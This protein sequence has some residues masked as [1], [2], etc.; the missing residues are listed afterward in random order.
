MASAIVATGTSAYDLEIAHDVYQVAKA[1]EGKLTGEYSARFNYVMGVVTLALDAVGLGKSVKLASSPKEFFKKG[2]IISR[3]GRLNKI[4]DASKTAGKELSGKAKTANALAK[5]MNL[6]EKEFDLALELIENNSLHCIQ[7]HHWMNEV[8][9]KEPIFLKY[10]IDIHGNW[11]KNFLVG[12]AGR[13]SNRYRLENQRF[14]DDLYHLAQKENFTKDEVLVRIKRE[15]ESLRNQVK[16][17]PIA[18][19]QNPEKP[20]VILE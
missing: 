6:S 1:G 4:A 17:N 10:N 8:L 11:N 16:Q 15:T 2:E 3:A 18:L 14:L 19:Y 5:I 7:E 9:A 12:H 13:H 20:V